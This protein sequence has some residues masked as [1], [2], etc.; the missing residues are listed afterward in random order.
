MY[1][2]WAVAFSIE[3]MIRKDIITEI[4]IKG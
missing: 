2:F 1:A 3:E 4:L